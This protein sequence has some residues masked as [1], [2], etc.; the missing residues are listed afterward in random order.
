LSIGVDIVEMDVRQ[1][2]DGNLVIIHDATV[3]RT[4]DGHGHVSQLTTAQLRQL[5]LRDDEGG[6]AAAIT[7]QRIMTL[8]ELLRAAGN[9]LVLNL[10]VKD[11]S[12]PAVVDEV[13]RMGAE[14][15]VIIKAVA[16]IASPPLAGTAPFDRVTF[17]P[18]L[19]ASD[20]AGV[21]LVAVAQHQ[22]TGDKRPLGYELPYM[23]PDQLPPMAQEARREGARIWLNSLFEGFVRGWGGDSVALTKP[24]DVWGRMTTGG[25]SIIQ[26]DYPEKLAIY[27]SD[28]KLRAIPAGVGVIASR[29]ARQDNR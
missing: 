23:D 5:H 21:D 7:D 1:S 2:R 13:V 9:G 18:I 22:F 8:D 19:T 25:V 6:K 27:L 12:Y 14:H 17:M 11:A 20:D 16:G 3:D 26:T 4:T 28:R 24:D 15:R 10:D 29:P